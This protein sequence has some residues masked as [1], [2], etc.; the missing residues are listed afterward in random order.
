MLKFRYCIVAVPCS[1]ATF[2]PNDAY[3]K[4]AN[5][6]RK[7][8]LNTTQVDTDTGKTGWAEP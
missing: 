1:L 3:E 2:F 5:A 6:L 7:A 4:G 8:F